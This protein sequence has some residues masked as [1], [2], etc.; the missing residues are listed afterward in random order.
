M[1]KDIYSNELRSIKSSNIIVV[2]SEWVPISAYFSV[3][4]RFG[5]LYGSN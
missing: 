4:M 3:E 5:L 2:S 1:K